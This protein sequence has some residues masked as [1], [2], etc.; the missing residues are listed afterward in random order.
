MG[1]SPVC[2]ICFD[3]LLSSY[4]V[5]SLPCGHV[6]HLPC[7]TPW[8]S[9]HY[10]CP[11]CRC[12]A[13]LPSISPLFLTSHYE[14]RQRQS[15]CTD[16]FQSESSSSSSSRRIVLDVLQT[17]LEDLEKEN[18]RIRQKLDEARQEKKDEAE[19]FQIKVKELQDKFCQ[20]EKKIKDKERKFDNQDLKCE[21]STLSKMNILRQENKYL[22]Q[23]L[24]KKCQQIEDLQKHY[25]IEEP[26]TESM[27]E[28][29]NFEKKSTKNTKSCCRQFSSCL[30]CSVVITFSVALVI[31]LGFV[32]P[33]K[34][35]FAEHS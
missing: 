19:L 30:R 3:S 31:A 24:Y 35:I 33:L 34:I 10:D 32:L 29:L 21:V 4:S 11:Q 26:D 14:K 23:E 1:A 17:Q 20:V 8:V 12:P 25:K 28:S 18:K 5:S 2:S 9:S 16:T 27:Y 7:I 6:F 15:N 22:G 13:S